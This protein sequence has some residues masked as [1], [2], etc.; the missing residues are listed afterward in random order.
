MRGVAAAILSR[1]GIEA[2][3]TP[4]Y[5]TPPLHLHTNACKMTYN[6]GLTKISSRSA[7]R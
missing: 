6:R 4:V 7:A 3:N 2:G 1:G 5:F